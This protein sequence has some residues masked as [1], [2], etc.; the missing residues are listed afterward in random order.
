MHCDNAAD[1]NNHGD[2]IGNECYCDGGWFYSKC[3]YNL[4]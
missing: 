2:C 4:I 3:D 1:C